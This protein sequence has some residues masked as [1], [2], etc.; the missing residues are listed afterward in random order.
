MFL[1]QEDF[2][3]PDAPAHPA[4]TAGAGIE[5]SEGTAARGRREARPLVRRWL[6]AARAL[7]GRGTCTGSRNGRPGTIGGTSYFSATC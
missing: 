1:G 2:R 4:G 7:P 5:R 6:G 3:R